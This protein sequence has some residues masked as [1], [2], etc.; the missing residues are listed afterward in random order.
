MSD[1]LLSFFMAA[2]AAAFAYSKLGRRA[3][4]GNT[5]SI[6]II[7][8]VSFVLTFLFFITLLKFVLHLH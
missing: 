3:G 5:Q 1:T 4:Y 6:W 8:G 7:V 2:G